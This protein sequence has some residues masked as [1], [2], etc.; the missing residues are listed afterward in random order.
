[1]KIEI[2]VITRAHANKIEKTGDNTYK[3][4]LTAPPVDNK[5]NT[6]LIGVL[7]QFFR[8]PKN[9][10]VIVKGATSKTK[11]IEIN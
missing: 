6:M 4:W 7:A 1:M 5:A 3:A 8:K 9:C 10:I 2:K 11:I